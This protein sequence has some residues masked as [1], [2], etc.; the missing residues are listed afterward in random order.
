MAEANS[1]NKSVAL[2]P[3]ETEILVTCLRNVKGGD[4]QVSE[5]TSYILDYL[6]CLEDIV[7]CRRLRRYY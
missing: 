2:T 7:W 1:S 6:H 3:R 5:P 4:L